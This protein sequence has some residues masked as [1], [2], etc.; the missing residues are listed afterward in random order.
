MINVSGKD[1][2]LNNILVIGEKGISNEGFVRLFD[3]C[4]F[5]VSVNHGDLQDIDLLNYGAIVH[6][7]RS[8]DSSALLL[9]DR[10]TSVKDEEWI[11]IEGD[12]EDLHCTVKITVLASVKLK[13]FIRT[14]WARFNI[15]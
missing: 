12:D 8:S 6:L 2:T 13:L 4:E 7:T 15:T 11:L 14:L 3:S 1:G 10:L 9:D 5:S